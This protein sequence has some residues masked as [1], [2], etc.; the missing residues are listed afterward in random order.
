MIKPDYLARNAIA[1]LHKSSRSS[2]DAEA[3]VDRMAR[4]TSGVSAARTIF[5]VLPVTSPRICDRSRDRENQCEVCQPHGDR[6][7]PST[8]HESVAA[9]DLGMAAPHA[10][11]PIAARDMPV[12][13]AKG[14]GA[15]VRVTRQYKQPQS[16]GTMNSVSPNGARARSVLEKRVGPE[17]GM[18]SATASEKDIQRQRASKGSTTAIRRPRILRDVIIVPISVRLILQRLI[19]SN[20][21]S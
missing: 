10:T 3:Q 6:G 14:D 5:S 4:S 8:I 18:P 17:R 16:G 13:S 15:F 21:E 20:G 9:D 12:I 2:A 19:T 1:R 7:L 11:H